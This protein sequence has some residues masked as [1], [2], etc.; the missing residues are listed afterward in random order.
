[1]KI[2][3]KLLR[4]F[5]FCLFFFS[6]A[7]PFSA[8]AAWS[9]RSIDF[10]ERRF[11]YFP[12]PQNISSEQRGAIAT[13]WGGA[14]RA[15]RFTE[16]LQP[17]EQMLKLPNFFKKEIRISLRKQQKRAPLVVIIPGVFANA[18][19]PLA[20][21]ATKWF[22]KLGYHI[23]TIP[24]CWGSDFARAR[25]LFTDDYPLGEAKVITEITKLAIA[26]IGAKN[27]T[28]VSL[29][30]ESL[31]ALAAAVVYALD[32]TSEHRVFTGG[33]TLTWPPIALHAAVER[34][35][36][37]MTS[38]DR[39]YETD[40]HPLIKRVGTKWRIL[41]GKY[42][43][44]PTSDEITCAPALVAQYAFRNQLIKLAKVIN[45][46]EGLHRDVS[47]SLT[48]AT[49]IR[50][51][52]SRYAAAMNPSDQ[53]G[54][55]RYWLHQTSPQALKEIRILTSEDDFLNTRQSW[56]MPGILD[57]PQDQLIIAHWGGHIGLT[58]TKAYEGLI[59]TQFGLQ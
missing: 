46:E 24:D 8:M 9:A 26:Q 35:D 51:Y 16:D 6:I 49:F 59:T 11:G 53:S 54:D 58:D 52:A 28:T 2:S 47:K 17:D 5:L 37:M 31:G 19:D 34:L 50:D 25:P 10:A 4:L 22:T 39:L 45:R 13:V 12:G 41:R 40:C 33:A 48:F 43:T 27:I 44:N 14:M 55:L 30:G 1:M 29:M 32:S 3:K 15:I 57:S 21:G 36:E 38:T 20:R 7:L 23:L 56:D 18:D 42:I